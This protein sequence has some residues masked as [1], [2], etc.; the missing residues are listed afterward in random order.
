MHRG[1]GLLAGLLAWGFVAP[2][3]AD[4][5][6]PLSAQTLKLP[7]GPSSL[8]G[9][10]ESFSP[11]AASGTGSFSVPIEVPPGY[12]SPKVAITYN[13]GQGK[14]EV[15]SGWRLPRFRIYR[16][17]DK[18]LPRFDVFDR[19]GVEGP[20]LNDEL[21][22]VDPVAHRYRL[23]NEGAF[24]LFEWAIQSNQWVIHLKDGN[25]VYVGESE[26]SRDANA[27]GTYR[28]YIER[29]VDQFGH[30]ARYAYSHD[31]GHCYLSSIAYQLHASVTFQNRVSFIYESRTDA[32]TDYTYGYAD[33][34]AQ[35]LARIET[36]HG[37]RKLRT[38]TLGYESAILASLLA[39]VRVEGEGG[40][41]MP[42]LTF[43]YVA[44]SNA[45]QPV[46]TMDFAPP[47]EGLIN[48]QATM[49]D[50]NGD[51]LPD[52]LYGVAGDY[53]YYENIDGRRWSES[54]IKVTGSPDRALDEPGAMLVDANG[55]GFRD[56]LVPHYN[57]FRYYPGGDIKD[58]L[59]R[60]F[61]APVDFDVDGLWTIDWSSNLVRISD[62]NAD[63]RIDLMLQR[64]GALSQILNTQQ[65]TLDESVLPELPLDVDFTDPRVQLVDFN[66]DGVLDFVRKEIDYTRAKVRVWFGRGWGQ[67]MPEQEMS[68]VPYGDGVEFFLQDVDGDGQTDLL[69]ISGSD[70]TYY[71]NNGRRGFVGP[72]GSYRGLPPSYKAAKVLFADMNGNGT[73]DIVWLTTDFE[74]K[75]LDLFV[76]PFF[77]LLTRVDNGMGQVT[78]ITYKAS[79]VYMIAAKAASKPWRTPIIRGQPVIAE[80]RVSD[81]F[82]RL[83][84]AATESR[85]TYDYRDGYYEPREREFRGFSEVVMTDY[86]DAHHETKVTHTW[87]SVGRNLATG[88]DEEILKGKPL[89]QLVTDDKGAVY[90]S[91]ETQWERRW[92]CNEVAGTADTLLPKCSLHPDRQKDKDYLVALGVQLAALSGAWEKTSHPS[93]TYATSQYD[94]WGNETE[95]ASYGEITLTG[96]HLFG[97]VVNPSQLTLG[98]G[99]DEVITETKFINNTSA[100]AWLIG[101]PYESTTLDIEGKVRRVSRTYYDGADFAGLEL[102]Q[103]TLGK[104]TREEAWLSQGDGDAGRF[105]SVKRSAYDAHGQLVAVLDAN[106]NRREYEYDANTHMFLS[107]ERVFVDLGPLAY[108]A[109]Y[110]L[111]LGA[112][113]AATDFNG[114]TSQFEY[115]GLGRLSKVVDPLGSSA[116]PL[117]RYSYSYGTAE[118]PVSTTTV[119]SLV[120]RAIGRYATS[121]VYADGLGRKRLTK[122]EAEAPH[123]FVASGWQDLSPRGAATHTYQSF[124]SADA[125]FEQPPDS[126]PVTVDYFDALDRKVKSFPP[127]S[128]YGATYSSTI[129]LPFETFVYDERDT[130][131]Q[132][133]RYPAI[134]RVD[135][136]GRT[137]EITKYNDGPTDRITLTWEVGYDPTGNITRILDPQGHERDYAYDTLGRRLSVDDPNAGTLVYT[138]DDVGNL[139]KRIDALGQV[140][141]PR[142]GGQVCYAASASARTAASYFI[143]LTP[144]SPV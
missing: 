12:L 84:L 118:S 54:P 5:P 38:Y 66:G 136:Q 68:G 99:E 31:Q 94:L 76:A 86:G 72:K 33:V 37:T 70:V 139:T 42:T 14:G 27:R 91:V 129:Y 77:G 123:F 96:G 119:E 106:G 16:T 112:I 104:P 125:G 120:D 63:G 135:G 82:D 51:A 87:F 122:A 100:S 128:G 11:D 43:G 114:H 130:F 35:R 23:K 133:W 102:G 71:L 32:S 85:T 41:T 74:V 92:L 97:A 124:S 126:T 39:S 50:V 34:M 4:K 24:A 141:R 111:G 65:N 134:T 61:G 18:G 2:A 57:T 60:G 29:Q 19:F 36:Y 117:S 75:Y 62:L 67:Y 64:P 108:H 98:T 88:D 21:V 30:T 90:S 44:H 110:D 8:K 80:M 47:L 52:I 3:L 103:A 89:R 115:D 20:G 81:S 1:S 56:V 144:P 59:F 143:G 6:A 116:V 7:S 46:V 17:T 121:Y 40:L 83:G 105:V 132:T 109:D 10:G 107:V 140:D 55:D 113:T 26:Q 69:R 79:T 9:L 127:D 93:Y 28:W 131:E 45:G 58:G 73:T 95:K 53:Y 78:T 49:E 22:V 15:G 137:R 48:G 138:Y 13:G 101:V 25:T 142:F